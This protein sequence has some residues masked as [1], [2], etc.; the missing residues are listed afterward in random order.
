[1]RTCSAFLRLFSV[2]YS[3]LCTLHLCLC[4]IGCKRKEITRLFL[5]SKLFGSA[6]LTKSTIALIPPDN[7]E[8]QKIMVRELIRTPA[9]LKY[10]RVLFEDR[11]HVLLTFQH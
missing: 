5:N 7:T 10:D 11:M 1:M 9:R 3:A 8:S 4:T 2:N 6:A